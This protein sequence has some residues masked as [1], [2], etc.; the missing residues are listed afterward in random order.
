[1][2]RKTNAAW[3]K[4]GNKTERASEV[5]SQQYIIVSDGRVVPVP[6]YVRGQLVFI[7]YTAAIDAANENTAAIQINANSRRL[8]IDAAKFVDEGDYVISGDY[9]ALPLRLWGTCS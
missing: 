1:M 2:S 4:G 7:P 6:A 8:S 9:W 3:D 5:D